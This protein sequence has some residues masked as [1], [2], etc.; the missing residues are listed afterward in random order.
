MPLTTAGALVKPLGI[1]PFYLD[2]M[3]P[4][5]SHSFDVPPGRSERSW[6]GR[7][8]VAGRILAVSGHVHR[9]GRELRLEDVT[10]GR[11][12]WRARP[13]TTPDGE[14][15]AIPVARFLHRLGIAMRAD[16]EYRFTV[17]Y[18]NPTGATIADGGMGAL[19]GVFL[20]ARGARWPAVNPASAE[21]RLDVALQWRRTLPGAS[22]APSGAGGGA[23]PP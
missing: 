4:A 9:Y 15:L 6:T 14:V 23:P 2:V 21:Y 8:A 13:D 11:V 5:G 10:A 12:L 17:V 7:P 22:G 19:G 16:H 3:P 18:D 1:A 20:P